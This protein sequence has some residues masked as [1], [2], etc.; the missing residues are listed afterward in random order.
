MDAI[1][2]AYVDQRGA[3]KSIRI[4]LLVYTRKR[5]RALQRENMMSV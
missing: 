5:A 3:S 1:F 2:L 4:L